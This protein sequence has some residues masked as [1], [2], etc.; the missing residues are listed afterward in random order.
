MLGRAPKSASLLLAACVFWAGQSLR[1]ESAERS[2]DAAQPLATGS[3]L[4]RE[5]KLTASDAAALDFF[6]EPVAISGDTL[7]T[8][9][10]G[11]D[12]AAPSSGSAYVFRRGS[13]AWSVE[14]KLTASD[15]AEN[16]FFGHS[17]AISGDTIVVGADLD[18]DAGDFSGSAYVFQRSG[19]AWNEEAKLTAGD[20]AA[21][22]R[23]GE[24]V[25][26]S[27][28]TVVVGAWFNDDADVDSGSA[29]VFQRNGTDWSQQAKLTPSDAAASDLF[30]VSVAI[31]GDTVV[32]GA[33]LDDDAGADSG[34]AY[35]FQRS[36]T[37][38]S[39][40]AKLTA[41]D[42]AAGDVFGVSVAISGDTVVVGAYGN[43]DAGPDSGSAYVFQRSGTAWSEQ[44][45]LTAGNAAEGDL[46]GRSV[47][48]GGDIAVVG[49]VGEDV[50]GPDSGSA[51]VFRRNGTAWWSEQAKL[52]ASDAAAEDLFG[53]S[54]AVSGDTVVA[55]AVGGSDAG[56]QSGSAYVFEVFG[57][58]DH[59]EVDDDFRTVALPATFAD[60]VVIAGPPTFHGKE[61][62]VVR[63]RQVTGDSFQARFQEWPYLDGVHLREDLPYLVI[64]AGRHVMPDGSIWE[65]GTFPLGGTGLFQ[66]ESF[67]EAFPG[68]PALFLTGQ[69]FRGLAAVIVRARNV[70][71]TGFDA[72][73][74]EQESQ[75][76]SGHSTE[77]VG[78]LAVYSTAGSGSVPLLGGPTAAGAE[79]RALP[80]LV[81][82][83]TVNQRFTP[84]LGWTL[85][86][87]EEKS[88]DAERV[89]AGETLAVLALGTQLFAQDVSTNDPDTAALRRLV[90]A[91]GAPL[92]WGTVDGVTDAWTTV[93][94]ARHYLNPVVVARPVSAR[95]PDPGVIR[96]RNVTGNAFDLRYQEWNYLGGTHSTEE[97]VFYMVAE[98][99]SHDLDG[100]LVEAGTL[101]TDRLLGDGF[102][103]VG[104]AAAFADRPAV[105]SAVQTD[106]GGDTVTTRLAD[107]TALGFSV[108]MQEEEAGVGVQESETLGWIAIERGATTTTDGRDIV[109][110]DGTVRSLATT[111]PFGQRFNRPFPVLLGDIATTRGSDPVFLRYR[112]LTPRSV[113]LF[114]QEEQSFDAETSHGTERISIFVAE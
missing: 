29:Y 33:W 41:S 25:A 5:T 72:A 109:V 85:K 97:R 71:A 92:E 90:P 63:L 16:D 103:T 74:F 50:A 101:D 9:A 18:G 28:D 6:G 44:A 17:V 14:A 104:F 67:S 10:Q 23:F 35:V 76:G 19:T 107:V 47:S 84:V 75:M 32:V 114:L 7:V 105:F 43:D 110:F 34:S 60:P 21:D 53:R 8:G 22:D 78:Y 83:P 61:P 3:L 73:Q 4:G 48:V 96:L 1:S 69:T 40:Q 51:Y 26:I 11:D 70:T 81:R 38:W 106:A 24:S 52:T 15:A 93:P 31:S 59:V 12:D 56:L 94:L 20:A 58:L 112:N 91:F 66:T 86:V 62:G 77:E 95:G 36:G 87:E 55:G 2:I 82:F 113:Q 100:L 46:F 99:G 89:H 30:G 98:A 13:T 79:V 57:F 65:A 111:I 102:E 37:A 108:T 49:A 45:K 27:G 80:Y 88:Q 42:A 68:R 39:E 54:V 64:E